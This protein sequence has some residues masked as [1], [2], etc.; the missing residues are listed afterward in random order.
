MSSKKQYR[1][2]LRRER[3]S[4]IEPVKYY[5]AFGSNLSHAQMKIRAPEA[6]PYRTLH[7][8][9]G[10][11]VFR[12]VADVE[13]AEGW[14]I[15][16]ALWKITPRCEAALDLAEGVHHETYEKKFL[17]IRIPS[18]GND[19]IKVLYYK[20]LTETEGV[21]P[22]SE[23]YVERI[24]QGYRDFGLDLAYLDEALSRAWDDKAPTEFLIRRHHARGRPALARP[25]PQMKTKKRDKIQKHVAKA[26][27]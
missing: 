18:I 9:N 17:K 4:R 24:A 10:R 21:M 5:W 27:H 14:R 25:G 13:Y 2:E 7:V 6:V 26:L 15:P 8:P 16:G 3:R 11:L 20:M 12:G 19:Q 23:E 1:N 22:P